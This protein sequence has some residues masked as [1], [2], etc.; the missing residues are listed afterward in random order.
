MVSQF[1]GNNDVQALSGNTNAPLAGSLWNPRWFVM[2]R[3]AAAAGVAVVLLF[4]MFV[5][6]IKTIDYSWLWI[7]TAIL[8]FINIIF[9]LYYR[10]NSLNLTLDSSLL[11]QRFLSFI[12]IQINVDLVILTLIIHFSGGVT[13]PFFIFYL[14]HI[15]I[16][17]ILLPK[18]E[19]Y[20]EAVFATLLFSGM[21]VLEATGVIHHFKLFPYLFYSNPIYLAGLLTAFTSSLFTMV[22]LTTTIMNRLKMHQIW[23]EQSLHERDRLV[24]EKSH[25]LDVVSHD[26]RSPLAA[27]ETSVISLL[28]SYG[29]E[30]NI[31]MKETLERIPK[32]TR[33]LSR[34]IQNLLSF[35]QLQNKDEIKIHFRHINFLPI[36]T[37]TVEMY[38]DEALDK[39]IRMTVQADHTIPQIVGSGEHLERMVGNLI[40]NAIRYTPEGGSINVKVSHDDKDVILTVVDTGIGI[41]EKELP[42][43]Y[44]EFFRAS[45]ARKFTTAGTGL[46]LPITRFIVEKHGGTITANSIEGEGSVFTVRIPVAPSKQES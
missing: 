5:L 6:N 15:V 22:Y 41:P 25:F 4:A 45:N 43:L 46:G 10:S 23:L 32:R 37:S 34:F 18:R 1:N 8:F 26:I 40:S 13:N 31:D 12:L 24:M 19:K 28:D 44:N 30:M 3:F 17:S 11:K 39:K 7:L 14:F 42:S 35:S 38:M 29:H 36:V 2:M 20:I 33:D 9:Y 16:A 27:I 21:A